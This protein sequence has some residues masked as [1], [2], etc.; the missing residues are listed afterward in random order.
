MSGP[1]PQRQARFQALAGAVDAALKAN[2]LPRAIGM[3]KLALGEGHQHPAFHN[4]LAAGEMGQGRFR[5]ALTHLKDGLKLAPRDPN[6]LN[7]TGV[8]HNNLKEHREAI[9]AFD[10]A[11]AAAPR[12]PQ[13]VYNRG[14]AYEGLGELNRAH[15]DF[16][17]AVALDPEFSDALSRLAYAEA[18]RGRH[19]QAR[20]FAEK[21]LRRV[22]GDQLSH[23]TLAMGENARDDHASAIR[24]LTAILPALRPGQINRALALSLLGDAYDGNGD[25][26]KAFAAYSQSAE[27]L[28]TLY[29]PLF[30]S[31]DALAQ[32]RMLGGY[33]AKA[34]AWRADPGAPPDPNVAG[35]VFLVGFPRSGTTLLEQTLAGSAQVVTSEERTFLSDVIG[36]LAT[37][38]EGLDRLAARS[39][40]ELANLR[41]LYW[42][43]A[44]QSGLKIKDKVFIDKLPLNTLLLPAVAK[45]FPHA[46]ILFALRDPRDVVFSCFRRSFEMSAQ[47][48]QLVTL[49]GAAQYYDAVMRA[50]ALYRDTLGL[51][52]RDVRHEDFVRDYGSQ[53]RA[54]ADWLGLPWDDAM[55]QVAERVGAR[56]VNTPSS[57][58]IARGVTTAGFAAWRRYEAQMDSLRGLLDPWVE[59]YGYGEAP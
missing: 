48:Y 33:F 51:A 31:S 47:M 12:M 6:L 10:S 11:I 27:V 28:K 24:R 8:A 2:D 34:P 9:R 38:P 18:I 29:A 49:D 54:V 56:A 26:A 55:V 45:L 25:A 13:P 52:W 1:G 43:A 20:A 23:I 30:A 41:D 36:D 7:M 46:K 57:Q 3:A 50:A 5:E 35:H 42:K 17:R 21:A 37:S 32:A 15:G 19:D 14:L 40:Q 58:Q 22:P 59:R 53:A 16:E 44:R 4:I 39:P